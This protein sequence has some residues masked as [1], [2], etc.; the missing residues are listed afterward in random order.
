[1]SQA[2][3]TPAEIAAGIRETRAALGE[4]VAALAAKADVKARAAEGVEALGDRATAVT[5]VIIAH[6]RRYPL[7]WILGVG[8]VVLTVIAA[9]SRR[10]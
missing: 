8:V 2:D 3:Q 10:R 5:G 4:T 9:R 6:V 1:M 7:R